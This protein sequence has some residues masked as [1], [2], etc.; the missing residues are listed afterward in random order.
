MITAGVW[1]MTKPLV[2]AHLDNSRGKPNPMHYRLAG[3]AM[4]HEIVV[5]NIGEDFNVSTRGP[6]KIGAFGLEKY[7]LDL[8]GVRQVILK[9][10]GPP[11]YQ[12]EHEVM[13][14]MPA[15]ELRSV[16]HFGMSRLKHPGMKGRRCRGV[17]AVCL[18]SLVRC[19]LSRTR[20]VWVHPVL[21]IFMDE[22]SGELENHHEV[23]P[24]MV[25]GALMSPEDIVL[26]RM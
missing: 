8:A 17:K 26:F 6:A 24:N 12:A 10:R 19:Q 3:K 16:H 5:N 14:E 18:S 11:L 15:A 4:T 2:T 21:H 25:P 1:V 7:G 22:V 20:S 23:D 13:R 9:H